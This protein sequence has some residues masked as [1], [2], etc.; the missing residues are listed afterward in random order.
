MKKLNVVKFAITLP[1]L[2]LSSMSWGADN[3]TGFCVPLGEPLELEYAIIKI[4]G[5]A[6]INGGFINEG[7]DHDFFEPV[8]GH[9]CGLSGSQQL[10]AADWGGDFSLTKFVAVENA[11][12]PTGCLRRTRYYVSS[13]LHYLKIEP[14]GVNCKRSELD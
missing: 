6:L 4:D 11:H 12:T 5:N 14:Q 9:G 2:C 13:K 1:L 7:E 10:T 8:D 3:S